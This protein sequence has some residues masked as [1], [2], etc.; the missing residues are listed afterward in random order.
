MLIALFIIANA[1]LSYLG[2]VNMYELIV[3]VMNMGEAISGDWQL[4][5]FH[6]NAAMKLF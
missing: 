3:E 5:P 1:V 2:G 6:E 4:P